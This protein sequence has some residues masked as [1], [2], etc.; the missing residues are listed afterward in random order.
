MTSALAFHNPSRDLGI[1]IRDLRL[2]ESES[3]GAND[4]ALATHY[5]KSVGTNEQ[6]HYAREVRQ[7]GVKHLVTALEAMRIPVLFP[8]DS[9]ASFTFV[10]LFAGIGGMRLG[11]QKAGGRCVFSSEWDQHSQLTYLTNFGELPFGDLTTIANKRRNPR[12]IPKHEVLT[13]GFPCQA[14]SIAGLRGGFDDVRGNLFTNVA[15]VIETHTPRAF[16]LENVKGLLSH[17]KG[18]TFREIRRILEEV[19]HYNIEV[20]VLNACDFE[21]PQNRERVFIVGFRSRAALSRFEFPAGER[22]GLTI[23]HIR[24]TEPV[25]ARY[26]LSAQY[27]ET[28][29]RHRARHE[30]KGNGFGY[31]VKKDSDISSAVVVGGMG[32][33]RNLIVDKRRGRLRPTTHIRGEINKEWVRRMTPREWANLQGFPPNFVIPVKDSHAYKQFGNSVPVNVVEAIGKNISSALNG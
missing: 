20:K 28:L 30:S 27:L 26:Y 2:L 9:E 17:D 8:H 7:S 5:L 6:K 19:M 31:Q 15:R 21:L 12:E 33:E 29:K 22:T 14:F 24:E 3:S 1:V 4:L 16:L 18:N 23:Q 11:M 32:R 10:D 13:A 25:D